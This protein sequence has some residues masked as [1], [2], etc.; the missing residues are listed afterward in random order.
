TM[1][2]NLASERNLLLP[3]LMEVAG[4]YPQIKTQWSWVFDTR[5]SLMSQERVVSERYMGVAALKAQGAP[6]QFDNAPG[7]RFTYNLVPYVLAVGYAITQ[8]AIEDNLY[9]SK[10]EPT[11]LG[12]LDA[13]KRTKEILAMNVLNTATTYDSSVGG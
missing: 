2:I 9:K 5:P 1:A 10:F 3:G 7:D 8:E 6:I 13:F 12:L 11:N 4:L